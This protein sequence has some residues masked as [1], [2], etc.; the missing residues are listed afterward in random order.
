MTYGRL[1]LTEWWHFISLRQLVCSWQLTCFITGSEELH[2]VG[3]SP[4]VLCLLG[5]L[6][7]NSLFSRAVKQLCSLNGKKKAWNLTF[8]PGFVQFGGFWLVQ[9]PSHMTWN[10]ILWE[11]MLWTPHFSDQKL[12]TSRNIFLRSL[13][14]LFQFLLEVKKLPIFQSL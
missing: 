7:L 12:W 14:L 13:K 8:S 11:F 3:S 2:F 6:V 10:E 4:H 9:K 1:L 5:L